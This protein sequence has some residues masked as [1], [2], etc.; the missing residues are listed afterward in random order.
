MTHM[1]PG[2]PLI[3]EEDESAAHGTILA[4]ASLCERV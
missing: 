4:F 2:N 1:G 3:E